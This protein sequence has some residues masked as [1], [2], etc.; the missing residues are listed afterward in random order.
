MRHNIIILQY[1]CSFGKQWSDHGGVGVRDDDHRCCRRNDETWWWSTTGR[2]DGDSH[3]ERQCRITFQKPSAPNVSSIA[4]LFGFRRQGASLPRWITC[5]RGC[6]GRS[7]RRRRGLFRSMPLEAAYRGI[8]L[9][10]ISLRGEFIKLNG[11]LLGLYA[12]C[13]DADEQNE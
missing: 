3:R 6:D 2:H 7:G 9:I 8:V 13:K 10:N 1:G 12:S 4:L 11:E 5:Q